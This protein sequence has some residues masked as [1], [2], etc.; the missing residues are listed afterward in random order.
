MPRA[1]ALGN[2]TSL[3]CIDKNARLRD[4]YFPH[5]GLENHMGGDTSHRMGVWIDGRLSWVGDDGWDVSVD[6][7]EDA[8]AGVIKARHASFA[9]ELET[10]DVMYNEK[11]I[12][13]R[14]VV[15]KNTG[16]SN[17]TMRI[18]FYQGFTLYGTRTGD[19]AYFDPLRNVIIHYKGRRVFLINAR[20]G[21]RGFDDY[22]IGLSH[23]E[24]KEGTYKDAEDGILSK[25]PIEH[26]PVDSTIGFALS[27]KETS[28]VELY[29]WISAA[30]SVAE[31][32][33]LDQYVM[34]KSPAHLLETTQDFWRAWV[35]KQ[36]FSF[37]GLD[38]K[39]VR[40]FEK[41]L[42]IIRAHTDNNGS[43]IASGDS[44]MLQQGRDTYGYM[45]PRD[46]ARVALA[47]A[48]AGDSPIARTF[49]EFC[50]EI[51]D[52]GGYFMHK[53]RPDKSLGSSWHPW[54][55]DG[56]LSLPIQEDE[57]ALVI[58]AL[59]EQYT[60]SRDVEFIEAVYNS[61]IA[62]AAEFMTAYVD[63][64]T[65]LPLPSY[66]LWEEKYG[67]ST[68]TSS[69]VYGALIAAGKF[70]MLL[71]KEESAKKYNAAARRIQQS[72][73][74]YLVDQRR[75][76]FYKLLRREA[77]G[78]FGNADMTIDMSSV[79]GVFR[80]GILNPDDTLLVES[81][82]VAE[83]TLRS[84]VGG[85]ARYEHDAYYAIASESASNPWFVTTLWILQYRIACAKSEKDMDSVHEGLRWVVRYALPSGVLSEQLHPR[86]GAQ[87][88][89][90]PLTW[91]HA[92][93]VI[94]VIE[95]L[96]R[97][98]HLGICKV[99]NPIE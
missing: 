80:F 69:A 22:G 15:F 11:N 26:G 3:V 12:F 71:G 74:E 37:Y 62:R 51:I 47:L 30:E 66:D 13:V 6:A 70:A 36:N 91:S 14:K 46:G 84:P 99:S 4:F 48:K 98:E 73:L 23:S 5:V 52:A 9:V 64:A 31:A 72:L 60:I 79:Y 35:H 58:H 68:F 93:F 20:I 53:Y 7:A 21:G 1:L 61:L 8:L 76:F 34:R 88:S 44:D 50:N 56:K 57:T 43:I 2:G 96:E 42:F 97:L 40:L 78:A 24:G 77:N 32:H 55:R 38:D 92:E 90:A 54:V 59:W 49:F 94:T 85:I 25:N 33:E 65:G 86:S 28:A 39:V 83:Q 16:S 89:A 95:Y 67:T 29:Y 27:E 41:S 81:M 63:H 87:L 18:F 10:T 82:R 75:P 19:T 45:W 17:R